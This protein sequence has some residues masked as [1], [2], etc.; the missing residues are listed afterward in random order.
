MH[1]QQKR[2]NLEQ[3]LCGKV[4]QIFYSQY[5]CF[6]SPTFFRDN[7][8]KG[9]INVPGC[10]MYV[11]SQD[12]LQAVTNRRPVASLRCAYYQRSSSVP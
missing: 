3:M 5:I 7:K 12:L 1:G 11:S 9:G 6:G 4:K 2:Q 10:S 8:K